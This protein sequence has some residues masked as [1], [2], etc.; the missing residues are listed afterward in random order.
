[1]DG[2]EHE[3]P[4]M[5]PFIGPRFS[6]LNNPRIGNVRTIFSTLAHC[7]FG[8]PFPQIEHLV[9]PAKSRSV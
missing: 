3:M 5:A 4:S 9:D 7:F 2:Y 6:N 8:D 1:M